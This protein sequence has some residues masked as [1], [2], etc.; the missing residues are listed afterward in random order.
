[1]QLFHNIV[2]RKVNQT[3][4]MRFKVPLFKKNKSSCTLWQLS[5]KDAHCKQLAMSLNLPHNNFTVQQISKPGCRNI[6]LIT[7]LLNYK[8]QTQWNLFALTKAMQCIYLH[9]L[10][11]YCTSQ[12]SAKFPDISILQNVWV[13]F[14]YT[15]YRIFTCLFSFFEYETILQ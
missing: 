4:T 1:M 2:P 11:K 5:L 9:L 6:P 7:L 8:K 12:K 15:L 13:N 10:K 14:S 3:T